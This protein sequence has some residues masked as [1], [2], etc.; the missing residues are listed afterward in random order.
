MPI[1]EKIIKFINR[2]YKCVIVRNVRN[3]IEKA[4]YKVCAEMVNPKITT[5]LCCTTSLVAVVIRELS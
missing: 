5:K 1:K 3:G 4:L 2:W